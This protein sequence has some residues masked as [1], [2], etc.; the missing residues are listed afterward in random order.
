MTDDI[1]DKPDGPHE[2]VENL[3]NTARAEARAKLL[4]EQAVQREKDAKAAGDEVAA[5][6]ALQ[7]AIDIAGGE[8][9]EASDSLRYAELNLYEQCAA[10]NVV[11]LVRKEADEIAAWSVDPSNDAAAKDKERQAKEATILL[12]AH[13]I[14]KRRLVE[15][16]FG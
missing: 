12:Q 8:Y 7:E 2:A 13:A 14:L 3:K 10:E 9:H 6:K 16:D 15:E 5:K 1:E 4:H 11:K